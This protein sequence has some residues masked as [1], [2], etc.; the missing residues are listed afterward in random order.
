MAPRVVL[1]ELTDL[2][3]SVNV[4]AGKDLFGNHALAAG[5]DPAHGFH[6]LRHHSQPERVP[7]FDDRPDYRPLGRT[8]PELP[9]HALVNLDRVDREPNRND[10]N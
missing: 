2:F 3:V 6:A 5:S 7:E 8:A 4:P 1:D 10:P 9:D